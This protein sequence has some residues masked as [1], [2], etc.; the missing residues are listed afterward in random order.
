MYCPHC[1]RE[2]RIDGG[3]FAC[4]VGGMTFSQNLHD[5]LSERFPE[6]RPRPAGAVVDGPDGALRVPV[7]EP[8][9]VVDTTAA[10]DSFNA[11]YMA[12]RLAGL[13]PT[14]AARV[15]HRVAGA[16]VGHPGAIIPRSAMPAVKVP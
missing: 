2:M 8:V 9:R 7:E 16:V 5:I 6:Q 12:A 1:G 10:G 13:A 3:V 15:G 11:A 4:D 14:E